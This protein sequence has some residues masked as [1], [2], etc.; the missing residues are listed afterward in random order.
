MFGKIQTSQTGDKLYTVTSTY[1]EYKDFIGT[2]TGL[3]ICT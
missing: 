2:F 1:S 3:K